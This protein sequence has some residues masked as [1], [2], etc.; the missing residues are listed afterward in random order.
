VEEILKKAAAC[1]AQAE[2]GPPNEKMVRFIDAHRS[3]YGVER[4]ATSCRSLRLSTTNCE[5]GS[6]IPSAGHRASGGMNG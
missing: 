5:R 1:F 3:A 4:S 6:A 2:L